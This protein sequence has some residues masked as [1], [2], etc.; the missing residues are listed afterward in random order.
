MVT[1]EAVEAVLAHVRPRLRDD[2]GDVELIE[3]DHRSAS[4][5]LTG[6]CARCPK[7]HMTL[8]FGIESVL[9]QAIPG[10]ETLRF[11]EVTR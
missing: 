5:R 7:A 6:R 2:G 8:S 3:V 9:R 10:F 4:V 11:H 1:R